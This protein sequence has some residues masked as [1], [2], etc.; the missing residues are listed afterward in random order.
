MRQER[1]SEGLNG[2]LESYRFESYSEEDP[3]P[4]RKKRRPISRECPLLMLGGTQMLEALAGDPLAELGAVEASAWP[5]RADE[6]VVLKRKD[7]AHRKGV[8]PSQLR[9]RLEPLAEANVP[10]MVAVIGYDKTL[11]CIPIAKLEETLLEFRNIIGLRAYELGCGGMTDERAAYL[12]DVIHL[13]DEHGVYLTWPDFGFYERPHVFL[14]AAQYPALLD[15]IAKHPES[16]ILQD[17]TNGRGQFFLTRSVVLGAWLA[18][19]I[20][21]W[22]VNP[23]DWWWFEMGYGEPFTPSRGPRGYA[24]RHGHPEARESALDMASCVSSP[25]MLY[26]QNLVT[27]IAD[28]ATVY[29]FEW[30]AHAYGSRTESG[31]Y[32]LSPAWKNVIA[33]VLRHAI[34][35]KAIPD[36]EQVRARSPVV[37]A[38]SPAIDAEMSPP[39]ESLFR[40]LYG[41]RR[42][43][44]EIRETRIS[45]EWIPCC[46]RYGVLPVVPEAGLEKAPLGFPHVIKPNRFPDAASQKAWFDALFP[47]TASGTAWIRES[48]GYWYVTNTH[49][50]EDVTDHF[51][52]PLAQDG[53]V[54]VA[55]EVLPYSLFIVRYADGKLWVHLNNY[56]VRTH[57]W[58]AGEIEK[59]DTRAYM[60]QYVTAPD[61]SNRRLSTFEI[62]G[63][64]EVEPRLANGTDAPPELTTE[65]L[66]EQ[67]CLRLQCRHNGPVAMCWTGVRPPIPA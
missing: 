65:W 33:P 31:E 43:D 23:E 56:H 18:G 35:R 57:I 64:G 3:M 60:R 7:W 20:E 52:I 49:E 10:V 38:A 24:P 34:E 32:V 22:G 62:H 15:A 39:A 30:G 28:G 50:N 13:A 14:E 61:E 6:S 54:R 19:L 63:C 53:V 17:K 36:R 11:P 4:T 16:V 29:S 1:S 48:G 66:A 41:A 45:P 21:H 5:W 25:D 58:D 67:D 27:A 46:G 55:G 37:Y 44:E 9:Q 8:L 2:A 42:S 26:G 40:P 51:S 59:F 47:E 12:H